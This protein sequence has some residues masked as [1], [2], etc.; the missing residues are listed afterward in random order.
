MNIKIK[1][2]GY[3]IFGNIK[4]KCASG[5][6]GTKLFKK[7]GDK[8]TPKGKFSIGKLYFRKDRIQKVKTSLKTKIIRENMGWCHDVN[9]KLYNKEVKFK[10]IKT[11]ERLFR[12]DQKY[13]LLLVIN[14]NMNPIIK[15]KGSAIFLHL[16]KNFKHTKGCIAIKKKYFLKIINTISKKTKILIN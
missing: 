10:S 15:G 7:E 6:A 12:S 1:K 5:K 11:S 13:D 3:L 2:N 8:S 14:Y 16:T 9:S 4:I